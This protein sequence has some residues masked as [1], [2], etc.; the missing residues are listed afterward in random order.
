MRTF[1]GCQNSNE[2]KKTFLVHG[3]Y[4]VQQIYAEKLKE[5][6]FQNIEIPEV[7]EEFQL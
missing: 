2:I 7:G 1:L 6:G 5:A 3:E 4:Q